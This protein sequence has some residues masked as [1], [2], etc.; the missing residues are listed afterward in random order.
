MSLPPRCCRP[1][2]GRLVVAGDDL[3]EDE[4]NP[5][6]HS[7]PQRATQASLSLNV[8]NICCLCDCLQ[9]ASACD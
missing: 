4:A 1:T 6:S 2:A 8:T 7:M 9:E 3:L 5:W